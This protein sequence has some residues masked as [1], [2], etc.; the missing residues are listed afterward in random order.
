MK[1]SL[2]TFAYVIVIHVYKL[3]LKV[4]FSLCLINH[5]ATS[6]LY[7]MT[8]YGLD[9]RG[10]GVRVP[11]GSR[12]VHTGSRAHPTS[13]TMGTRDAFLGGIAAGA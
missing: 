12:I 1:P 10:V 7:I 4:K 8:S 6:V 5:Y 11:V 2:F 9:E 3:I 13:Y